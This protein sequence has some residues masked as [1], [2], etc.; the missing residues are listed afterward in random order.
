MY[1][2]SYVAPSNG[3]SLLTLL[4]LSLK[5]VGG[6]TC[7]LTYTNFLKMFHIVLFPSLLKTVNF[8]G[9]TLYNVQ[10]NE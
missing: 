7:R 2:C 9:D 1:V 8:F 6:D 10:I 4:N 3:H 5:M